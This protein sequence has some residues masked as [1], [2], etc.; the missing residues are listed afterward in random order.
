M[1]DLQAYNGN[2]HGSASD[3]VEEVDEVKEES[4]D[5]Q[6]NTEGHAAVEPQLVEASA[7]DI[8]EEVDDQCG[9]TGKY[10]DAD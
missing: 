2:L 5:H 8:A 6:G 9:E 10:S 3:E 1:S 7:D 4:I